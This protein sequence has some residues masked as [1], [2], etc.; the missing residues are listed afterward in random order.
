[1]KVTWTQVD[2]GFYIESWSGGFVGYTDR[3]DGMYSAFDLS[4]AMIRC[5]RP[6]RPL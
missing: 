5:W 2:N 4:S 1:M 6:R 3:R